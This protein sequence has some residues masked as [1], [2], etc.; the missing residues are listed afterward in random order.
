M[1][2]QII[3]YAWN[4]HMC[5]IRLC[6]NTYIDSH[7]THSV[8]LPHAVTCSSHQGRHHEKHWLPRLRQS[9]ALR[10]WLPS[11][12]TCYCSSSSVYLADVNPV[13]LKRPAHR[14][15]NLHRAGRAG[16]EDQTTIVYVCNDKDELSSIARESVSNEPS[17][18]VAGEMTHLA[19]T[20]ES[21]F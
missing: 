1:S 19:H 11:S 6:I 9:S 3:P 5:T 20:E 4:I 10:A 13:V 17:H 15:S 8:R 14:V 7:L 12:Q 18:L 16:L 2:T 21:A